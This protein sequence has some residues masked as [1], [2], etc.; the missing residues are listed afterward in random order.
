[1]EF[2]DNAQFIVAEGGSSFVVYDAENEKGYAYNLAVPM[3]A[4][5]HASWMDGDRLTLTTGGHV[6]VFDYDDANQ[7]TLEPAVDGALPFFDQSYKWLYVL[8][9]A[10]NQPAGQ[11]SLTS[12]ALRTPVDQ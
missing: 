8:A 4:G 2:S 9:P 3:A 7:Q 12:T 11:F 1:L 5:Q 10:S 6:V